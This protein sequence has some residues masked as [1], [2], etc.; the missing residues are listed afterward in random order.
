TVAN[1]AVLRGSAQ[2]QLPNLRASGDLVTL[3][4]N[5][6]ITV[7][8]ADLGDPARATVTQENLGSLAD[9]SGARAGGFTE[10]LTAVA[11]SLNQFRAHPTFANPLPFAP[12]K[13]F[14][15]VFDFLATAQARLGRL[16]FA[17]AQEL[18]AALA[19]EFGLTGDALLVRY[20]AAR[21]ELTYQVRLGQAF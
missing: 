10:L 15:D 8:V 19:R 21:N 20:D 9:F 4:A 6:R 18:A 17:T 11:G 16:T 12:G 13:T 14:A 7:R 3:P 1:P 2:L 5:A